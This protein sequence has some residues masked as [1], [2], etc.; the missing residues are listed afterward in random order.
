MAE[1]FLWKL[2]AIDTTFDNSSF[3]V[4][5]TEKEAYEKWESLYGDDCYVGGFVT[6]IDFV[7]GYEIIVKEK[8]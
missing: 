4:A 3:A 6:K 7:D 1:K 5:S 2:V 8:L